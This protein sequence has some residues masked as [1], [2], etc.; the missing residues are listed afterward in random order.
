M[1]SNAATPQLAVR[2]PYCSQSAPH[3][4]AAIANK[5]QHMPTNLEKASHAMTE[6]FWSNDEMVVSP[7]VEVAKAYAAIAQAEA[8]ERIAKALEKL[9]ACTEA[10][11]DC[12]LFNVYNNN[13]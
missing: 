4:F 3:R 10:V 7:H 11:G 5:E 13:C 1:C 12:Q 8:L 2:H 6:L 9:A